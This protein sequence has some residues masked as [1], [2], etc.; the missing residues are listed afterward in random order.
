[1]RF[2]ELQHSADFFYP[3]LLLEHVLPHNRRML[4][5]NVLW[6]VTC[7]ACALMLIV[8]PLRAL[9]AHEG[10]VFLVTHL[11]QIRSIFLI[12]FAGALSIELLEAMYYSYY[13][14]PRAPM[15]FEVA[16]MITQTVPNDITKGFLMS[17]L[18][19]YAML[20]LGV[21]KKDIA[22]F[23][24]HR[25][26]FVTNDEY[27]VIEQDENPYIT[28]AEYARSIIH[29]DIEFSEFLKKCGITADTFKQ[30]LDW[31][32]SAS[33]TIRE[34]EMWWSREA[35]ERVPSIGK[36][37]AYGQ[38]YTI[39]RFGHLI[40]D[41]AS[42]AALG[43]AVRLYEPSVV[44]LAQ[45]LR[46]DTGANVMLVA[47]ESF[48][49]MSVVAALG[50]EITEGTTAYTLEGKRMYV[51]D[52]TTLFDTLREKTAIEHMMQSVLTQAAQ[53]GNVIIVIP[54]F[55]ECVI[56]AQALGVDVLALFSEALVSQR[57]QLI[58]V[59]H[60][61]GYHE[62]IETNHEFMRQCERVL[63]PSFDAVSVFGLLQTEAHVLE[64]KYPVIFTVQALQTIIT[65]AD[66]YFTEGSLAHRAQMLLHDVATYPYKSTYTVLTEE[67]VYT[68]VE[69]K[70]DIAQGALSADEQE[71]LL[72]LEQVLHQ[73]IVGQ[74]AA[75][76]AVSV[77][78][79]RARAGLTN[80]K[81][82]LGS[83]LFF[84]PTG[85]GKTETAKVLAE[86]F[87]HSAEKMIRFDMSE[88]SGVD[89]LEMLI[90]SFSTGQ[91][92]AL[93]SKLRELRQG[94]LLL[95]EFE[96]AHPDVHNLFLQL[97]DEG[98]FTDGRG[99][100]IMARNCIIIATSNAGSEYVYNALAQKTDT[101]LNTEV[102]I[103]HILH[104]NIFRPELVNRFDGVILFHPLDREA[105][106]NIASLLLVDLND[107]L[108]LKGIKVAPT[109]ALLDYLV[110][111]GNNPTF[112]ARAMRR[113]IQDTVERVLADGLIAEKI[114][115]GDTVTLV[116]RG[117][118]LVL[119]R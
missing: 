21:S 40:T 47:D 118:E 15:D 34:R 41:D 107:R 119:G 98:Y 38:T 22:H 50:K 99:E 6:A 78:L 25:T 64:Q 35:L 19:T 56:S 92:G 105:L 66:R 44:R 45:I 60:T 117:G 88:Y 67:H 57:V 10:V 30:S 51:L 113:A 112:G 110:E 114:H 59:T 74:D 106:R 3:G 48:T 97:L 82:P 31:V 75:V 54:S 81:R 96:K 16:Q 33:R 109:D 103:E 108:V 55:A 102:L 1:M 42:Y 32:A 116:V 69:S 46:K 63:L 5:R 61:R 65:S 24:E 72:H 70:T 49:A 36:N 104:A 43:D 39:E 68:V 86:Q 93:S 90:G 8:E 37:W 52:M 29:F 58:A 100:K 84:G 20:R 7:G 77:A 18:G 83:F 4:L 80:P 17:P 115:A 27:I 79:R 73:R 28:F 89:A 94:V 85:V 11:Y 53:A 14:L 111:I 23:L 12:F 9:V 87:F 13:F 91:P 2:S 76:T 62:T 71:V 26:T 95:D 101:P